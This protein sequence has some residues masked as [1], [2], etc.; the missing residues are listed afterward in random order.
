[1]NY[2]LIYTQRKSISLQVNNE[3]E[4][5]VKAPPHTSRKIIED[6]I[7]RKWDWIIEQQNKQKNKIRLSP[8]EIDII[9]EAARQCIPP[10]VDHYAKIMKVKYNR[11]TI[12]MQKTR[13]GSCS[14][15]KNLNFNC[16]LMLAPTEVLDAVIVHELAHLK[17]MNHSPAFYKIVRSVYPEYD[18]YYSWLK[19]NASTIIQ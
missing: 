15:Q 12:K 6:L 5:I 14:S 1:M 16:L 7:R 10:R 13:W 18:K 11:I 3:G 4:L 8:R 9:K 19:E 17:E 2:L